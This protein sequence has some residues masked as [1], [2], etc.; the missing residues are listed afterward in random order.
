[1]TKHHE[2]QCLAANEEPT[3]QIKLKFWPKYEKYMN[4][5]ANHNVKT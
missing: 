5:M 3:K 2:T 4:I 1:M